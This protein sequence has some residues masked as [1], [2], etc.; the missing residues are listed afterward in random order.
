MFVSG[1]YYYYCDY[2]Y[3]AVFFKNNVATSNFI[4]IFYEFPG[5]GAL[6]E[7][8]S[9]RFS[10]QIPNPEKNV[11]VDQ[12]LKCLAAGFGALNVNCFSP[13]IIKFRPLL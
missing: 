11:S 5:S 1:G 4:K 6:A 2:F 10:Q 3:I 7:G 12:L 9:T 8:D 13:T